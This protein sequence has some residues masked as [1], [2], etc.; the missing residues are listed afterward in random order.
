MKAKSL[1]SMARGMLLLQ[2]G[3]LATE[4]CPKGD[5]LA[6]AWHGTDDSAGRP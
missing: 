1:Y 4:S 2:V 6:I 3:M 5:I